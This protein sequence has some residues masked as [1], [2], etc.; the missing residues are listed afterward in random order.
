MVRVTNPTTRFTVDEYFRMSEAGLFDGRRVELL[1][2]RIYRMHAQATPHMAAVTAGIVQLQ[3]IALPNDWVVVQG[4][5]KLDKNSAPDP[6]LMLLPVPRGT[7]SENWP[8]P[9][10]LV[11]VSSSTYKHDSGIKLR[12]YAMAGITDY[13]IVNLKT[14]QVEVYRDPQNPSGKLASCH[15]AS[16]TDFNAN[17][18]IELLNRP[19][20][21]IA[22]ADL[23][24]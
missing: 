21:T 2:G 15:Y 5:L 22:V 9:V 1:N 19:G 13:W 16:R 3:R 18:S 24:K 23:L 10:L 4:T 12:K 17:Q 7:P 14:D 20:V 6:D 11:E 8:L